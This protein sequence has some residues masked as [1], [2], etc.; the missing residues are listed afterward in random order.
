[1]RRLLSDLSEEEFAAFRT[2]IDS[3]LKEPLPPGQLVAELLYTPVSSSP[4][5]QLFVFKGSV[6]AQER[7]AL[8]EFQHIARMF[9]LLKV[10]DLA[11]ESLGRL[12]VS[13]AFLLVV[14]PEEFKRIHEIV[15]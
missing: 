9:H 1:M 3:V 12:G 13:P 2:F 14:G 4:S 11:R 6:E 8:G 7:I 10:N 15:G 5:A